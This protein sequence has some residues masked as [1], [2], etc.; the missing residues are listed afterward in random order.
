[1]GFFSILEANNSAQEILIEQKNS[2][3]G[4]KAANVYHGYAGLVDADE[5]IMVRINFRWFPLLER[6]VYYQLSPISCLDDCIQWVDNQS[7]M[8]L[9]E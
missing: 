8:V 6:E 3:N 7:I 2:P 4:M 1:M 5:K 9:E